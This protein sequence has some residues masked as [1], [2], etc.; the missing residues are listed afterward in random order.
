M[1]RDGGTEKAVRGNES[2]ARREA[3]AR[4]FCAAAVRRAALAAGLALAGCASPAPPSPRPAEEPVQESRHERYYYPRVTSEE[5]YAARARTLT[6][7]DKQRRLGF[8]A[9]TLEQQAER[10]Y[11]PPF[12]LFAKGEEAQRMIVVGLDERFSTLYR[13]RAYMAGLTALARQTPL[14]RDFEVDHLFTFYDLAKLMGFREIVLSDG[15]D[16]AHRVRLAG[17]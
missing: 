9:L 3:P 2:T 1:T 15:K 6:D 14:F 13:A 10:S 17:D 16:W 11:P 4:S 5:T 8:V 7:S 12:V